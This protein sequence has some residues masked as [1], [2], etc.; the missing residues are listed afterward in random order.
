MTA[1]DR[2]PSWRLGLVIAGVAVALRLLWVL[3]VPT[4]VVGDFAM[5]RESAMYLCEHGRLDDGFIYMPG[6]VLLLAVIHRLGG[7]VLASKM[8]GVGFGGIA[9]AALYFATAALDAG[10]VAARSSTAPLAARASP[11]VAEGRA[12]SASPAAV[13]A[14]LFALWLPGVSTA[15]VVGTDMPCAAMI[16]V[17]LA[18]LFNWGVRRP[19]SAAIAFG[20]AMGLAAYFRAVAL[21]LV[22]FSA[23]YWATLR[24]APRQLVARTALAVVISLLALSPWAI[25]NLAVNGQL[26]FTDTHGGVTAL[27]GN[28]PNTEGTYSRSLSSRFHALTGKTF[29]SQPHA[30][31]DRVAYELAKGWLAFQPGWTLGMIALRLERLLAPERGLLYWSVYRPGVLPDAATMRFNVHRA[32]LTAVTDAY[33][34]ILVLGLCA[35]IAFA[36][37]ERRWTVLLPVVFALALLGAYALFVAEPRYRLTSEI[38]AFP[39]AAWGWSRLFAAARHPFSAGRAAGRRR[40]PA[41][42]LRGLYGTALALVVVIVA[43]LATVAGGRLLRDRYRW[44][45]AVSAVDG[46]AVQT[47]WRTHPGGSHRSRLEGTADGV[48]LHS[49]REGDSGDSV[50]EMILPELPPGPPRAEGYLLRMHLAW[51][52]TA[53]R[54]PDRALLALW[55]RDAAAPFA[56]AAAGDDTLAGEIASTAIVDA[57]VPGRALVLA[58]LHVEP[59]AGLAS[60]TPVSVRIS[61]VELTTPSPRTTESR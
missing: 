40:W 31:T 32:W 7:E 52:L 24:I 29:L 15:S 59:V 44:A 19:R 10:T 47:Y 20:A 46:H 56:R 11:P 41:S 42:S 39:T 48:I 5:Y 30:A 58:R 16:C 34:W 9:A 36:I 27:M 60:A 6:L 54:A 50:I 33:G 14:V 37:T 45:V 8:L 49:G 61:Q 2:S 35:G 51:S 13:V 18:A 23:I 57:Q 12:S 21:P 55:A 26:S 38:V 1:P 17:A 43:G 28:D 22:A 25:R 53:D 4:I 3:T